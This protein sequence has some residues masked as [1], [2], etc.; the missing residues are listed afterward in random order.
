MTLNNYSHHSCSRSTFLLALAISI[1]SL[2]AYGHAQAPRSTSTAK[3]DTTPVYDVVSIKPTKAG[4]GNFGI[5][6]GD[7]SVTATNVSLKFLVSITY[8][9]KQDLISGI[10]GPVDSARFDMIAKIVDSDPAA[11]KKLSDKQRL[12]MV[13]P[14]LA[15]RF[16]LKAHTETK[17][18]PVYEL[19]VIP[20]GPKFKQSSANAQKNGYWSVNNNQGTMTAHDYSMAALASLLTDV[21]HRTVIDKTGLTGNYEISLK[22]SQDVGSDSTTDLG[23]SIFTALQEQLGLKLKPSKGPV[24]T[25]VVDHVAMPSEN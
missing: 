5:R 25:L 13:L 2:C 24:E 3:T 21:A 14:V 8:G 7:D 10:T 23:P 16:Q 20:G 11:M 19:L 12:A 4:D 1:T 22:W 9:I 18:L 15:E 17:I 6:T